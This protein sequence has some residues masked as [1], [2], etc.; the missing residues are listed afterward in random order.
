MSLKSIRLIVVSLLLDNNHEIPSLSLPLSIWLG[1]K[2]GLHEIFLLRHSFLYFVNFQLFAYTLHTERFG[3]VC[4]SCHN[5]KWL[6]SRL[7]VHHHLYKHSLL[8]LSLLPQCNNSIFKPLKFD[9][10]LRYD[11]LMLFYVK[12][13]LLFVA[14]TWKMIGFLSLCNNWLRNFCLKIYLFE[15]RI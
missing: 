15:I 8:S 5:C 7:F 13:F 14:F 9:F 11:E 10:N 3:I 2:R 6:I 1:L 12:V 4:I